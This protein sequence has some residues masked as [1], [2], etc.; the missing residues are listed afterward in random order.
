MLKVRFALDLLKKVRNFA[1]PLGNR[2]VAQLVRVHVWG[3]RGR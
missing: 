2:G 1:T 3:A